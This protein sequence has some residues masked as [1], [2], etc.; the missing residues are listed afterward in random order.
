VPIIERLKIRVN[1]W[2]VSSD[3]KSGHCDGLTVLINALICQLT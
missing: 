2:T 3:K 1:V